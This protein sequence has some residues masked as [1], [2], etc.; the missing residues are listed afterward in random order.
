M[1]SMLICI[2]QASIVSYKAAVIQAA[3][4]LR[5]DLWCM[6]PHQ[7]TVWHATGSAVTR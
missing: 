4:L 3:Q 5:Q 1:T 7:F 6:T 2:I